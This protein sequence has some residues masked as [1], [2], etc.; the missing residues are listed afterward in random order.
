MLFIISSS[1]FLS[2]FSLLLSSFPF[3]ITRLL[4]ALT[5]SSSPL[6]DFHSLI[7]PVLSSFLSSFHLSSFPSLIDSLL[8][9][10]LLSPLS[11]LFINPF[12]ILLIAFSFSLFPLLLSHVAPL[13]IFPL[14]SFPNFYSFSP[15][16]LSLLL[17]SFFPYSHSFPVFLPHFKPCSKNMKGKGKKKRKTKHVHMCVC[18]CTRLFPPH[19][20]TSAVNVCGSV[21]VYSDEFLLDPFIYIFFGQK[22]QSTFLVHNV[23]SSSSQTEFTE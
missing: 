5:L 23:L 2:W 10:F 14:F 18:M 8:S 11:P 4:I 19:T 6:F 1:F 15:R 12:P 9:S 17:Q 16:L 21:C 3:F 22:Q 7:S 20:H 13:L